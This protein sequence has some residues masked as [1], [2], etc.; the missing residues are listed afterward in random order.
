MKE[1]KY[2]FA[3]VLGVVFL[4]AGYNLYSYFSA[5]ATQQAEEARL[6]EEAKIAKE[7]ERARLA[8]E[9]Q[10]EA[11]RKEA[12][13]QA[14][15]EEEERQRAED[16]AKRAEE[17]RLDQEAEA[18]AKAADEAERQRIEEANTQEAVARARTRETIEDFSEDMISQVRSISPRYITDHPEEF[19]QVY[20]MQ[21]GARA[22]GGGYG[23]R[24]LFQDGTTALMIFA[25]VSQDT[26]A[27][28]ALLDTGIDL[29]AANKQGFTALMFAASYNQPEAVQFLLDK[30]AD[31]SAKAYFQD[32]N[33]LHL[34]S[35][36]NPNPDVVEA[37]AKAGFDLEA[38]T[39]NNLTPLILA[40]Q[41][42]PNLEVVERLASLGADKTAY[43]EQGRSAKAVVEERI[44]T[45]EP[46]FTAISP[47]WDAKVLE[48]LAP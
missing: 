25:A 18:A 47:E 11:E 5:Q 31:P 48:A 21:A 16:A 41:E 32:V 33:A 4:F 10:A 23:Q 2:L 36:L 1:K 7:A 12:E 14:I 38:K 9:K 35:L 46:R 30:G 20:D 22:L 17:E 44:A 37:L 13:R 8:A 6:A 26:V 27:L 40:A 19:L 3:A 39:L 45:G 15:L 43:D 34:A 24:L 42:N 29:N 28:Q